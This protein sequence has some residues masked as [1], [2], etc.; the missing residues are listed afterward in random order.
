MAGCAACRVTG[1]A[2]MVRMVVE[3][4]AAGSPRSCLEVVEGWAVLAGL[5]ELWC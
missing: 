4:L 2:R 5:V 1:T 3:G